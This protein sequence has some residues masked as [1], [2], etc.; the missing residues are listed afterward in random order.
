MSESPAFNVLQELATKAR[1]I[2]MELP[3]VQS[4]QTHATSLGFSLFE[5]R[6]VAS[7]GEVSE[8]MRVPP[9]TRVPGTKNFVMGV[10]NVRGRLMIV[11]DLA[12]FFGQ[13]SQRPKA[14]RRVLAV[15]ESENDNYLGFM[16]DESFG[17]QH[18][19]SDSFEE[20]TEELDEMYKDFVRGSYLIAGTR[21][22]VLSL[23]ALSEDPRLEKL[24]V[25]H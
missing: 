14:Q 16:I 18:F 9:V 15:E 12:L 24:A 6:F 21:W 2:S 8:M 19:P 4:A 3:S 10:G 25:A 5:Q 20:G 13:P 7:M 17:M 11:V 22:P 23:R 1:G